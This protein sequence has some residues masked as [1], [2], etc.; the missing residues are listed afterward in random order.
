MAFK[1]K[2]RASKKDKEPTKE[3]LQAVVRDILKEVDF[4]TVSLNRFKPSLLFSSSLI[5]ASTNEE[6]IYALQA[7]LADILKQLGTFCSFMVNRLAFHSW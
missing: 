3:E 5:L 7:T 1:G 6:F 2:R 4:N